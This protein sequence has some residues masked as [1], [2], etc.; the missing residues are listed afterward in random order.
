MDYEKCQFCCTKL[1]NVSVK[2]GDEVLLNKITMHIHCNKITAIVGP[3]GA[4]KTTLF[5]S[6]LGEMPYE[7]S[8]EY[9]THKG[10]AKKYSPIIGY[11]PQ[12]LNFDRQTPISVMDLF[13]SCTQKKPV[14]LGIKKEFRN[15]VIKKL[16]EVGMDYAIDKKIGT[17]SG[18]EL[19][20]VLVALA[21]MPTPDILMLDEPISG[22]DMQGKRVFYE[23]IQDLK[24]K[25]HMAIVIIT[26]DIPILNEICDH[27]IL[28]NKRILAEGTPSELLKNE[29]MI[30]TFGLQSIVDNK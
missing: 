27:A 12:Y 28:L 24:R 14:W 4:G 3:N 10:K 8:I 29:I 13:A 22:V 16:Q 21:L 18:G 23:M 7:G 5:K 26:H 2:K 15:Q 6:L 17:L 9:V 20:K 19:Q 30:Q 11:V 25:H 1:N